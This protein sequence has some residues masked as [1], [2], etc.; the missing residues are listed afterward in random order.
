EQI[1]DLQTMLDSNVD[2]EEIKAYA[3]KSG[4]TVKAIDS[5]LYFMRNAEVI[6][7][8]RSKKYSE[9]KKKKTLKVK[10][11]RPITVT[12]IQ[13]PAIIKYAIIKIGNTASIEIPSNS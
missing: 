9:K 5:K 1:K 6:A 7:K 2:R 10:E 3:K 12:H 4:R 11:E 13:A 8:K